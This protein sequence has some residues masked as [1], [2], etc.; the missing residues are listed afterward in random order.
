M[1]VVCWLG[2]VW[3]A[4]D[5]VIDTGADKGK[6]RDFALSSGFGV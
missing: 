3:T 2:L 4:I 1:V 6:T 5:Q